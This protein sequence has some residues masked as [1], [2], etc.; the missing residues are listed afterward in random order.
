MNMCGQQ[1]TVA[2]FF[3]Y[4]NCVKYEI[5][6]VTYLLFSASCCITIPLH[7]TYLKTDLVCF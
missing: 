2:V 6:R 4:F 1:V 3:F 7:V 5:Y